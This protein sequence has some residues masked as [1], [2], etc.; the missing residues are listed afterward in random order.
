VDVFA[1]SIRDRPVDDEFLRLA[2]AKGVVFIPT[3]I[4]AR[5]PLDYAEGPAPY[6]ADPELLKLYSSD[7]LRNLATSNQRR[8]SALPALPAMRTQFQTAMTNIGKIAAAGIPIVAGG[9]TGVPGRF[10]GLSVHLEMELL[11]KGGLS[12]VQAIQAATLNAAR[13]LKLDRD[14]GSLHEGKAADFIVLKA[15]PIGDITRTRAIDAVWMN[16]IEVDREGLSRTEVRRGE[17]DLGG[18]SFVR[19]ARENCLHPFCH[20]H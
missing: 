7:L 15:D 3:L 20:Q 13:M 8:F 16:G 17:I 6:L 1:H 11:V 4:Q 18:R 9:D 12:P 19:M 14:Y 5:F 10:H 2:L